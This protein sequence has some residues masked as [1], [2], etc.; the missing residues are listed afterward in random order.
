MRITII[1]A[2]NIGTHF[3]VEFASKGHEVIMLS[4]DPT[5][6]KK[7]LKMLDETGQ[8]IKKAVIFHATSDICEA[9]KDS[10]YI[11]ITYPAFMLKEIAE[12]MYDYVSEGTKI[13]VI[14]G[15]GGAEFFF[16]KYREKGVE[17]F[18]LQRVPAVARL[19]TYGESVC[20][21]G[22]RDKLYVASIPS[23]CSEKIAS[24]FSKIFEMP[25]GVLPNYLSVTLTPSNPILH[26]TRLKTLFEDYTENKVYEKNPLFYEEW[27]D[28][29]S[30]LLLK[31]DEELQNVCK[32]LTK[33][34]LSG[35]RSLKLH[36]ESDTLEELTQKIR[37]IKS[38]HGLSSPMLAVENGF[39]PD[40]KSRYFTAD[41]P[42]G[43][44]IIQQIANVV[45]VEVPNIDETLAWYY[46]VTGRTNEF[47]LTDYGL[48]EKEDFYKFYV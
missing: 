10:E 28:N 31:C 46:S 18:G 35:V 24:F 27:T 39:I 17:F 45:K 48:L 16:A 14:P 19:K 37:S 21:T 47:H 38:L 30:K 5:K 23:S 29:S 7:E 32:A 44:A 33:L 8:V 12:N 43:L 34:D 15:T 3:A 11:I 9:V 13:G 4:S 25:C 26:T 6:I 1:G 41:F 40:F 20:V 36:Y 2:G 42:Y 22:K